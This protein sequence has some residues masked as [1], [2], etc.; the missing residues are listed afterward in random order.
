MRLAINSGETEFSS[1][2]VEIGSNIAE[3]NEN[4]NYL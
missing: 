3:E 4:C 1:E 2:V